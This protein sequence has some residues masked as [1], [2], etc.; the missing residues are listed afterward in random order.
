MAFWD[1]LFNRVGLYTNRD[2]KALN[3]QLNSLLDSSNPLIV[4]SNSGSMLPL[5]ALTG[6]STADM[7]ERLALLNSWVSSDVDMICNIAS[8]STFEF[9][10]GKVK[11][12]NL[13]ILKVL[14]NPNSMTSYRDLIVFT[15]TWLLLR[16]EAYWFK[17]FDR[18]GELLEIWPIPMNRVTP[19]QSNVTGKIEYYRYR[20]NRG[21]YEELSPDKIV[22]FKSVNPFNPSRG[23]GKIQSLITTIEGDLYASRWNLE[24]FTNEATLTTL[25]SMNPN[26]QQNVYK[27][28]KNELMQ[29]LISKRKRFLVARTGDIDIKSIGLAHKELEYLQ[30]RGFNRDE[31]DRKFGFPSGFWKDSANRANM[32]ASKETVIEHTVWPILLN[33]ANAIQVQILGNEYEVKPT[34]IRPSKFEQNQAEYEIMTIDEVR[35][36]QGKKPHWNKDYGKL[37]YPMRSSTDAFKLLGLANEETPPESPVATKGLDIVDTIDN[38]VTNDN[39]V[40]LNGNGKVKV[41]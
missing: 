10:K 9:H 17:V 25:I 40:H 15:V 14:S 18:K 16:G 39:K 5:V 6:E 29:E 35:E 20:N 32:L 22:F 31:I 37:P 12:E 26:M 13:P 34:E 21:D 23:L 3:N 19:H 41:K 36:A 8:E 4:E 1:D 7:Q 27:Q 11:Q 28:V 38:A 2:I 24:T 30:G 33:M